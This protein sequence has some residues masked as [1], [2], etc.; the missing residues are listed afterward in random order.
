[1]VAPALQSELGLGEA[2]IGV[3]TSMYLAAFVVAQL[4]AGVALDRFGPRRVAPVM[5]LATAVGAVVFAFGQDVVTLS[6]GRALIGARSVRRVDVRL[7]GQLSST[8]RSVACHWPMP[9]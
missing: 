1:M 4:P 6:I 2:A 9:S 8:G 3:V 5:L 7:Q